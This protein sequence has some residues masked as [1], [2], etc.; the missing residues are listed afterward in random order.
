MSWRRRQRRTRC[1]LSGPSLP[2]C[3]HMQRHACRGMHAS[4]IHEDEQA[5]KA[6]HAHAF[7]SCADTLPP[8]CAAQKFMSLKSLRFLGRVAATS[9]VG[10]D[11]AFPPACWELLRGK[12]GGAMEPTLQDAQDETEMVIFSAV[13]DLFESTGTH[14]SEVRA[15]P[16]RSF[17]PAC[18][19]PWPTARPAQAVSSQSPLPNQT[20]QSCPPW[21]P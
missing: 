11:T 14:P 8:G 9:G 18:A 19:G 2:C 12:R 10:T 4:I 7:V 3:A 13:S 6:R 20:A 15:L 5:Y 1:A 21:Q 16:P 17:P